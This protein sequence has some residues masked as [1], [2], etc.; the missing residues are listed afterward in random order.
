MSQEWRTPNLVTYNSAIKAGGDDGEWQLA[1]QLLHEMPES[2]F[3]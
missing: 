1:M 3:W 2:S